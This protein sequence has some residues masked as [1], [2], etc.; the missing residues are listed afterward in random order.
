MIMRNLPGTTAHDG[1]NLP[2]AAGA[3][4]CRVKVPPWP[5]YSHWVQNCTHNADFTTLEEKGGVDSSNQNWIL[6]CFEVCRL[7]SP[8]TSLIIYWSS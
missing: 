4:K 5:V 2:E 1:V 7:G 3:S 8:L 6:S